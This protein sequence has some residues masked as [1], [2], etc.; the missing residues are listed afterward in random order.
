ML[1]QEILIYVD[2]SRIFLS[3]EAKIR[4]FSFTRR[5]K[6]ANYIFEKKKNRETFIFLDL[7]LFN[8][9]NICVHLYIYI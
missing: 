2:K 8:E 4:K 7:Q 5:M 1:S 3:N 6:S 9:K